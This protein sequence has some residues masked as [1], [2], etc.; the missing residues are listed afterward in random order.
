MNYRIDNRPKLSHEYINSY[1]SDYDIYSYYIGERFV[2]GK[3]FNSPL[4]ED[5]NPSFGILQNKE[6]ALIYNDL[7][8]SDSGNAITF[9]KAK[10]G[11]NTYKQALETIYEDLIVKGMR[12]P[13]D[14]L[15]SLKTPKKALKKDI[16]VKRKKIG[17]TDIDYWDQFGIDTDTLKLF[18]VD[19][20]QYLIVDD[21]IMWQY[22]NDNPI[23]VYKV[24][25]K[26][27]VYRPYA[28]K[29]GKWSG[30]ITKNY[31]FGYKQLPES[32]D[33][34]IITKSLKD[35]MCLHKLGYTAISPS[36]EGVLLPVKCV[37]EIKKRFSDITVLYDNDIAGIK[38]AKNMN[39]KYGFK[40]TMIK[41]DQKDLTDY[42]VA[43]GKNKTV[44]LLRNLLI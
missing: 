1:V 17:Q 42:Y 16:G 10:L 14:T 29:K 3:V 6:G 20:V 2:I 40:Y 24:Y 38:A 32:G 30:N 35:V 5:H 19:P 9:V 33:T 11:L 36:S 31:I 27:K 18:E 13:E 37:E 28:D 22:T 23:Y 4:R 15:K 21:I 41:G 43:N 26:I 7:A 25:D 8:I 39:E 44:E 12:I 34:L